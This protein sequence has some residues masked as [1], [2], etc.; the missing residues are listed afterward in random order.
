MLNNENIPKGYL[1]GKKSKLSVLGALN[2]SRFLRGEWA[3]RNLQIDTSSITYR[4]GTPN[5]IMLPV[6]IKEIILIRREENENT[7]GN[8]GNGEHF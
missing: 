8:Y 2:D 4:Q 7:K 1:K 3:V 5:N 6:V